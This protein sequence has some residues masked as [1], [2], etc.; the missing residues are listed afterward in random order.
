MNMASSEG[1]GHDASI[2]RG[3]AEGF[4]VSNQWRGRSGANC[5]G[6]RASYA[7]TILED[8]GPNVPRPANQ[9]LAG[10]FLVAFSSLARNMPAPHG[11]CSRMAQP[12]PSSLVAVRVLFS[13]LGL[14]RGA[15]RTL[16]D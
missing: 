3:S 13:F 11:L 10:P 14:Q 7:G 8:P 12:F 2:V 5:D 16:V 9:D 1:E 4:C 6:P 15:A